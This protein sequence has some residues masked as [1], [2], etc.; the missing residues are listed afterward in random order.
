MVKWDH[1]MTKDEI[2]LLPNTKLNFT[3]SKQTNIYEI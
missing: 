2:I 1:K 3:S